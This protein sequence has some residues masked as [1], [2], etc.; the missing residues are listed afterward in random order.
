[1]NTT[2]RVGNTGL[3]RAIQGGV[4]L[5]A[6]QA[7]KEQE[8]QKPV[9]LSR[10]AS[11]ERLFRGGLIRIRQSY[12]AHRNEDKGYHLPRRVRREAARDSAR[13]ILKEGGRVVQVN[14]AYKVLPPSEV[15]A[16]RPA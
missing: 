4:L 14:N 5:T 11:F 8:P 2:R 15:A 6:R 1:M 7:E 13:K 10:Q 16:L 12:A 3:A 9:L